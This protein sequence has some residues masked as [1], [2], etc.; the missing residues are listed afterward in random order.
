MKK[1]SLILFLLIFVFI[2][3]GLRFHVHETRVLRIGTECDYQPN[4]WEEKTAT[5]SNVPI[6]NQKGSYA[7]GYDIQI[8][9]LVAELIG[10]KLEVKKIA[11]N[12]LVQALNHNEIDAIF[13]GMLDTNE[14]K[15][16]IAFTETYDIQTT[17]YGIMVHRN[18]KYSQAKTLKDFIGASIL[19]QKDTHADRAITQIRGAIH[20]PPATKVNELFDKLRK[21]EAD[22]IILDLDSAKTYERVYPGFVMVKLS[23][24]EG[25]KFDFT[26]ICAGV[27][28]NDTKLVQEINDALKGISKRDRQRIMDQTISRVWENF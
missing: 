7:E 26:G 10:A 12:D 15:K 27:R 22:A 2:F 18:G 8:A 28:K 13:S 20:L 17:E 24:G 1:Y 21:K 9:K 11:W 23:E 19:A 25:F 16:N 6:I 5:D 14:R 4:N 3:A